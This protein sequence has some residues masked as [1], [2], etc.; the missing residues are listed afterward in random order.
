MVNIFFPKEA[1]IKIDAAGTSSISASTVLD[2]AFSA[3][4]AISGQFK[5]ISIT[6][7]IADVEIIHL[8]GTTSS[9]QNAEM[10]EKPAGPFEISGTLVV[11][12]DE[13]AES[14]IFGTAT[15]A[16]GTHSTYQP[17]LATR[18]KVELLLN[19]DDG[20]DEVNWAVDN[21]YVTQWDVSAS[22]DGHFEIAV[23]FKGLPKDFY[24]PQFKD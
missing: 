20:T 12:G 2:T 17:G 14:E 21:A 8:M 3:G 15:A 5:D 24:G 19:L 16:G 7:A 9:F 18:T 11:P 10:E 23:T 1:T 6:S 13:L 22:S 4:T